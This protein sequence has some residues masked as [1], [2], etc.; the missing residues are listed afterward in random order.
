MRY[1]IDTNILSQ[2]DTDPK[3]RTWILQ[4]LLQ[5]AISSVTVAEIA[6]GIEALPPGKKRSQLEQM[7]AE[8][9]GD[10]PILS[11]GTEEALIWG[12]YVNSVGRP[13]PI[14]DSLIAATALTHNLQVVTQNTSDFPGVETVN[15]LDS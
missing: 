14:L 6:Q 10:Y 1:L 9:M 4:H 15:P 13:L 12:R 2:Q 3:V 8:M 11:F 7:L 5:I